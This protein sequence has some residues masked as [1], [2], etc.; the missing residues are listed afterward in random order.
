MGGTRNR[1]V[2]AVALL[3]AVAVLAGC[4]PERPSAGRGTPV[5]RV[6]VMGDSITHGLFGTTPNVH[7]FLQERM[8]QRGVAVT[9]GG[10]P[11]ENPTW[12]WPGHPRWVD[13]LRQRVQTENPDMIVIQSMLFPDAGIPEQHAVYLAAMRE[14]LDVAQSRGAHVY[15]VKHASPPAKNRREQLELAVVEQLQTQA[16][17]QRGISW[18]PLE[19]WLA[20]C[21]RPTS[22]DGWHLSSNGQ[23]CHADAVTAAVD[24]LRKANGG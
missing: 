23:R 3:L 20:I 9:I 5:R 13:V 21:D 11:G 2:H 1:L 24:Q 14:I 4:Q 19:T 12:V 8:R 17:A 6:L 18:I 22:S 10:F 7:G 15:L 16:S